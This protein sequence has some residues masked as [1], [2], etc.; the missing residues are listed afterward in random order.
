M[1]WIIAIGVIIF[2]FW[3]FTSVAETTAKNRQTAE[4]ERQNAITNAIVTMEER[5]FAITGG[6]CTDRDT[7]FSAMCL[8]LGVDKN[9]LSDDKKKEML[10]FSSCIEAVFIYVANIIIDG[11]LRLPVNKENAINMVKA[12]TEDIKR[13]GGVPCSSALRLELIENLCS[14]GNKTVIKKRSND[15]LKE[16]HELIGLTRVKKEI[17]SLINTVKI[18]KMREENGLNQSPMSLH[19]VFSGNPGTGKT[20]VARLLGEIYQDLGIL[21]KG[22]L[23]EIDRAGMVGQYI[24]HTAIKTKEVINKAKGGIFTFRKRE[25]VFQMTMSLWHPRWRFPSFLDRI[26]CFIR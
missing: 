10:M 6:N 24:G 23:V 7:L 26:N 22:H 16:L 3:L 15:P 5:I 19:L 8:A 11:D 9:L 13:Y 12:T 25:W 17:T 18:S 4:A 21:S 14:K 1:G 2:I 20:T